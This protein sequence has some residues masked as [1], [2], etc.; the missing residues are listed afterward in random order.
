VYGKQLNLPA[1]KQNWQQFRHVNIEPTRD[2]SFSYF[3]YIRAFAVENIL[4][5]KRKK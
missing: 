1:A 3:E 4:N 5:R 2:G